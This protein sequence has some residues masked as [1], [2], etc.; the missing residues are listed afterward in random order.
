ME[1]TNV[2]C[3][4]EI[5]AVGGEIYLASHQRWDSRIRKMMEIWFCLQYKRL[6]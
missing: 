6:F 5:T 4:M 1:S 3:E 2:M